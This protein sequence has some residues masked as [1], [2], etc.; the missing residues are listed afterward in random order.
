MLHA[1]PYHTL[2]AKMLHGKCMIA[3]TLRHHRCARV[4]TQVL[5]KAKVLVQKNMVSNV[6]I[7]PGMARSGVL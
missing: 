1:T 7:L 3:F 4:Y 6:L 5:N 2:C